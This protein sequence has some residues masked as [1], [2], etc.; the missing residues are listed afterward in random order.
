MENN[1]KK[2]GLK[3]VEKHAD[4]VNLLRRRAEEAT[5]RLHGCP[6]D[7]ILFNKAARIIEILSRLIDEPRSKV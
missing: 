1:G 6:R 5:N 3:E 4:F 7:A 2:I